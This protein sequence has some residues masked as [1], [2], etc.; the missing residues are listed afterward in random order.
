M[1]T[2]AIAAGDRDRLVTSAE[3]QGE[4]MQFRN[5]CDGAGVKRHH[6]SNIHPGSLLVKRNAHAQ[7]A[8]VIAE[9]AQRPPP[10]HF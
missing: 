3:L 9:G 10:V 2:V 7:A 8:G 6:R 4:G 5:M 1:K